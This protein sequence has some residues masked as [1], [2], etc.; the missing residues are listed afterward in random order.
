[1]HR[2][3]PAEQENLLTAFLD[4]DAHAIFDNLQCLPWVLENCLCSADFLAN[5]LPKL[6]EKIER[7]IAQSGFWSAVSALCE[8]TTAAALQI[9]GQLA[10][11]PG[12]PQ[13]RVAAFM[14]GVLRANELADADKT[15]FGRLE[16]RFASHATPDCR[17]VFD[18]SWITT[19]NL[20]AIKEE[21][22]EALFARANSGVSDDRNNIVGVVSKIVLSDKSDGAIVRIGSGWLNKTVSP[23]MS[24]YAKYHVCEAAAQLAGSAHNQA[25][26]RTDCL[27]WIIAIQPVDLEDKGSWGAIQRYLVQLLKAD[28]AAFRDAFEQ[29]AEI[30]ALALCELIVRRHAW[31]W[32][33]KE[34]SGVDLTDLVG[35][36]ATSAKTECRCLGIELFDELGVLSIPNAVFERNGSRGAR[37]LFYEL[38]RRT[39]NPG[40]IARLFISMLPRL[41]ETDD[42]FRADFRDE[43]RLQIR[44]FGGAYREELEKFRAETLIAEALDDVKASNEALKR[45]HDSGVNAM[46]VAGHLRA[47]ALYRR[48]FSRQVKQSAAKQSGIAELFFAKPVQLLYGQFVGAFVNGNLQDAHPLIPLSSELEL[49]IVDLFDPEEMAMRRLCAAKTIAELSGGLDDD[50]A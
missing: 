2:L 23:K 12:A 6:A 11:S 32:L 18:W 38:Q 21:Q 46:E 19:A 8:R 25:V 48:R 28:V 31:D 10:K 14:L 34:L 37:L 5:W 36:L 33:L 1:M 13:I 22:L 17:S 7:D 3:S 15:E 40:S 29:L 30:N 47:S 24:S 4:Q 16:E 39:L 9:L 27:K 49:P 20:I 43:L 26:P 44:N 50:P 42:S 45:A 35:R 41:D